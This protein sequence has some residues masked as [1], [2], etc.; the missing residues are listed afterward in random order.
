[1]RLDWN[2]M[3]E[4]V[5]SLTGV[6]YCYPGNI[7][8]LKN[9]SLSI[10]N[11]DRVAIIGAN[12]TGKSTLLTMLDALIFA[13][14]GEVNAFGKSLTDKSMRDPGVQREFRARVGFV[15][16]NP[17]VQLFCP[18][19]REDIVFGPLQF[20]VTHDEI[21]RRL[22]AIAEKIRITHLLDRSP[23]QLSI[24]EKKKAAIASMLIMEPDVLLLDEPTA[25]LDPQTMRDIIDILEHAHK[26]GKT[27]V[28]ATHDLHI[29]EE[30]ADVV[31]VFGDTKSI[32]RSGSAEEV[33]S[34]NLFL[35]KNNL[36][37]IHVH[38]HLNMKHS[39]PHDH[40]HGHTH[41][42]NRDISSFR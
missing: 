36:V 6:D 30:I 4:P 3:A 11:G 19:V 10:N 13:D 22:D 38:R 28:M 35:Q 26:A 32:V 24:G 25:G 20:G 29:V 37:H 9:I 1:V 23:H 42:H 21:R 15:F 34:D 14:K 17:D 39:H 16:Q 27:V 31:H 8:A 18:T 7:P 33:L 2:A 5:F 40:S 41:P 12:G